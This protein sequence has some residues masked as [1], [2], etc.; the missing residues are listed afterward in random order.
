MS[1]DNFLR[2]Y[3]EYMEME[4]R[5]AWKSGDLGFMVRSMVQATMPHSKPKSHI[6]IRTNG[7]L[8]L[9]I[10]TEYP[11]VGL[12]YG[13]IPRLLMAF[14]ST[15]AVKTKSSTLILGKSLSEFMQQL[16]MVPTGGRWGTITRLKEQLKRLITSSISCV[17]DGELDGEED[18]RYA[19][20]K[21]IKKASLWWHPKIPEQSGIYESK[22]LLTEEFYKEVI[23]HPVP[24]D[25]R[26]LKALKRSPMALDI[27]CWLTYRM[28]TLANRLLI[29]WEALQMQFGADYQ[30]TKQGKYNFKM[31]FIK[32]L[33]SV[34]VLYPDAKVAEY[35]T[36]LE[37]KPS[38]THV[39]R[40]WSGVD[41]TKQ[42]LLPD[43]A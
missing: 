6:F 33:K 12:P 34:L 8:T 41:K 13:S 17:W 30:K 22:L 28:S 40:I 42:L 7:A 14:I 25:M 26:A 27:Y 10:A 11:K 15:E 20:I 32:H 43:T 36:G 18:W 9:T 23:D 1:E 29:P 4:A 37:L 35:D 38:P 16:D 19:H 31:A 5:S 21:L 2:L 39:P 3:R 24:I